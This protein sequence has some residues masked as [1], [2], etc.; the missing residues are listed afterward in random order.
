MKRVG[1]LLSML[2][3]WGVGGLY[4]QTYSPNDPDWRQ[5]RHDYKKTARAPWR[6]N[7]PMSVSKQWDYEDPNDSYIFVTTADI[8]GDGVAE[9]FYTGDDRGPLS[10]AP[11]VWL[12]IYGSVI[13]NSTFWAD[14]AA[15]DCVIGANGVLCPLTES[16]AW[17]NV[18]GY[19]TKGNFSCG[20]VYRRSESRYHSNLTIADVNGDGNPEVF[21]GVGNWAVSV[22]GNA[23]SYTENWAVNMG[24]RVGTPVLGD[25]DGDGVLEVCFP[26]VNNT[27]NCRNAINGTFRWSW[28]MPCGFIG[29][30]SDAYGPASWA[31][32]AV[33]AEDLDGDGRDELVALGS[34]CVAAFKYGVG[35]WWNNSSYGA[36]TAGAIGRLNSDP[37][38]DVVFRT[39]SGDYVVLNGTNGSLIATFSDATEGCSA[40]TIADITGDGIND[41]II[42]C[43]NPVAY[44]A[45]NGWSG[46][47]WTA[48]GAA[49]YTITS[50][51]VV[52]RR[53]NTSL[54]LVLGD[55]SCVTNLWSCPVAVMDY[56]DITNVEEGKVLESLRVEGGKGYILIKGY[57]GNV[58]IYNTSGRLVKSA[59]VEGEGRFDLP[60]GAYM[61]KLGK[62]SRVVIVR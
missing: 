47:V 60:S 31:T 58:E 43:I 44:S 29:I 17:G 50:D 8:N 37:Y 15:G 27:I 59:K 13:C 1:L 41:V 4:S 7:T 36:S 25:F 52:A 20:E 53:T 28:S 30:I 24:V 3:A 16:D 49:P 33:M 57:S 56:D 42:A 23:S 10:G 22:N 2:M 6:C 9:I 55:A 39:T 40:P 21:R 32:Q 12:N 18:D 14:Q 61:V 54:M 51:L 34:S 35:L 26:L 11:N 45:S 5:G 62:D 46:R 19:F 48:T 38:P